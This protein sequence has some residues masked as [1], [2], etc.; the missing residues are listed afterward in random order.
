[1]AA[2]IDR[3]SSDHLSPY[4]TRIDACTGELNILR[5]QIETCVA[6][7]QPVEQD[8][9]QKTHECLAT[10]R[11]LQTTMKQHNAVHRESKRIVRRSCN[12]ETKYGDAKGQ[13]TGGLFVNSGSGSKQR[14]SRWFQSPQINALENR[15]NSR[16]RKARGKFRSKERTSPL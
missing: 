16:V 9:K 5:S 13:S 3:A 12:Q 6:S 14:D 2:P 15:V 7:K 10:L 4:I 8:L 11:Q 1:M